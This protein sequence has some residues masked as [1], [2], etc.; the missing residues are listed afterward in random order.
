M[1]SCQNWLFP[2]GSGWKIRNIWVAIP[3]RRVQLA[4]QV[5]Q[6][7][8][9]IGSL[10]APTI[11]ISRVVN[12]FFTPLIGGSNPGYTNFFS[13]HL[14]GWNNSTV[15][16]VEAH[17]VTTL[18]VFCLTSKKDGCNATN[19]LF[20][21]YFGETFRVFFGNLSLGYKFPFPRSQQLKGLGWTF[22]TI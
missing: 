21:T 19:P 18:H 17:L 9:K 20:K 13:G 8:N 3:P 6:C 15:L 5:F 16:L 12:G 1:K 14:T 22:T 2:Q 11:F 10:G 4:P 7:S